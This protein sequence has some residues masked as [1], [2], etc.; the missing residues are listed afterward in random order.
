MPT[1]DPRLEARARGA[2]QDADAE[3]F[4][5]AVTAFELTDLQGRGRVSM[6]EDIATIAGPMGFSIIDFPADAWRV[7]AMLP[8]I[9]GDPIDR[10]LI[11]H[12]IAL[13]LTLVTADRMIARYPVKTLW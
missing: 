11:A 8:T 5:S 12:A 13:D 7:L 3:L 6:T 4:V 10:M 1:G 2:L 9:H